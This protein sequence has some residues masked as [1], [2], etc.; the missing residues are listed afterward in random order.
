MTDE[1]CLA[2][3]AHEQVGGSG[4][5]GHVEGLAAQVAAP[6]AGTGHVLD[7]VADVAAELVQVDGA[8]R[9]VADGEGARH[10]GHVTVED[11][12]GVHH[13]RHP[14]AQDGAVGADGEGGGGAGAAEGEIVGR[15]LVGVASGKHA[16]HVDL[17]ALADG[18]DDAQA[19]LEACH[20]LD[21]DLQLN[22]RHAFVVQVRDAAVHAVVAHAADGNLLYLV[23]RFYGSCA[24]H[25]RVGV[26]EGVDTEGG[27]EAHHRGVGYLRKLEAEL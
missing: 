18:A 27:G 1:G 11:A 2:V 4:L 13:H 19:A 6:Y 7:G 14:R 22:V 26:A 21:L 9:Q 15:R 10:V 17:H 16:A 12:V 24:Q 5:G 8:L 3:V 20:A 25:H 23:G